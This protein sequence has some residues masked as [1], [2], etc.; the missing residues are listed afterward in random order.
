MQN[1]QKRMV[2]KGKVLVYVIAIFIMLGVVLEFLFFSANIFGLIFQACLCVALVKRVRW[3]RYFYMIT[4]TI[5]A[6]VMASFTV[7]GI[8]SF[9]FIDLLLL[10]IFIIS[11]IC[12]SLLIFSKNVKEY[13]RRDKNKRKR[14]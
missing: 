14:S 4:L 6:L 5:I 7:S 13:F 12:A 9:N 8:G 11:T 10:I 1:Q 3:V 2:D